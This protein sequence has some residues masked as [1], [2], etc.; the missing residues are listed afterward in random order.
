MKHL[1]RR[2]ILG[3]AK[4]LRRQANLSLRSGQVEL[5]VAYWRESR[6]LEQDMKGR[7]I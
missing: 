5:A 1:L 4:K 6:R 7:R 2:I 3:R